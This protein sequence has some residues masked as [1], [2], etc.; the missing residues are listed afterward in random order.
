LYG[1]FDTPRAKQ[2]ACTAKQPSA[3][4]MLVFGEPADKR[5]PPLTLKSLDRIEDRC[6]GCHAPSS[7]GDDDASDSSGRSRRERSENP[8]SP[9]VPSI[10][11]RQQDK[12]CHRHAEHHL[13]AASRRPD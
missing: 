7:Q 4:L 1:Y 6:G 9:N 3:L 5:L 8:A 12:R 13:G 2:N 11:Q 10:G